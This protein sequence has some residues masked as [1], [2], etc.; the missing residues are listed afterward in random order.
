M[1]CLLSA[2]I[3]GREAVAQ[4]PVDAGAQD[5]AITSDAGRKLIQGI[6]YV[7]RK[8]S[9]RAD[10]E[11]IVSLKANTVEVPMPSR[12]LIEAAASL[13]LNLIAI[14]PTVSGLD[15][16]GLVEWRSLS[17]KI[18]Q[19]AAGM[20]IFAILFDLDDH[21]PD[22]STIR[23]VESVGRELKSLRPELLIILSSRYVDVR[24]TVDLHA[25]NTNPISDIR[26][27]TRLIESFAKHHPGERL[28][29][30]GIGAFHRRPGKL[31]EAETR[32]RIEREMQEAVRQ[33]FHGVVIHSLYDDR[34]RMP[35]L[36]S[37]YDDPFT[38]YSGIIQPT[39][40]ERS[41]ADAIRASFKGE[42]VEGTA[43]LARSNDTPFHFLIYGF[44][45]MVLI[46]A[47]LNIDRRFRELLSRA[48]G[49][50]Y[51]FFADVR[52]QRVIPNAQTALLAVSIAGSLALFTGGLLYSF[53]SSH[54]ASY[55][56]THILPW[57]NLLGAV[58]ALAWDPWLLL[59]TG[60]LS[61]LL[62]LGVLALLVRFAAM[63]VKGRI[64]LADTW[65]VVVWACLPM[66][67]VLPYA[68]IVTRLDRNETLAF[69]ALW[70]LVVLSMWIVYRLLKGV[71]V[72]FDI[73]P[74]RVYLYCGVAGVLLILA[75]LFHMDYHYGLFESLDNLS[76]MLSA[77]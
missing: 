73:Y 38:L 47:L 59:F 62:M 60:T 61:F 66:V 15:D 4:V 55:L 74:S 34:T 54:N 72:L 27:A 19:N 67:F 36:P 43:E 50:P 77:T 42:R 63:F 51:N 8:G 10:L 65:N 49:R 46:F 39:Q 3:G 2:L 14:V 58:M 52:D 24:A 76:K 20:P 6:R 18:V 32:L 11:R 25:I 13:G 30:E 9:I 21:Y 71:A 44:L 28:M 37:S 17:H 40:L 35:Y 56:L 12:Q 57:P 1:L 16:E 23:A 33:G 26:E 69:T 31:E 53:K 48:I 75:A 70:I 22:A 29:L 5:T 68:M 64:Y 7:E 45:L 41:I